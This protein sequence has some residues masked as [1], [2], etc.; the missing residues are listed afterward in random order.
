MAVRNIIKIFSLNKSTN[1][2]LQHLQILKQPK[3]FKYFT[4]TKV[5]YIKYR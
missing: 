5:Y 4:L 2:S 3:Y 1:I